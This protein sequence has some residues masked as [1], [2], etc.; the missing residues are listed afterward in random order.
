MIL[1]F[2]YLCALIFEKTHLDLVTCQK[3]NCLILS[4]DLQI[5]LH[6]QSK[7]ATHMF[8]AYTFH[9]QLDGVS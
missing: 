1:R 2:V 8:P 4:I 7:D 5:P 6:V 3:M 9:S